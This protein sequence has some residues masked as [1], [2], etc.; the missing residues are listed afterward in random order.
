L[1][2][3]DL[4]KIR[5]AFDPGAAIAIDVVR[6][7]NS[8]LGAALDRIENAHL[9]DDG[10]VINTAEYDDHHNGVDADVDHPTSQRQNTFRC[11]DRNWNPPDDTHPLTAARMPVPKLSAPMVEATQS[12]VLPLDRHGTR[13]EPRLIEPRNP[14]AALRA[15]ATPI[16]PT[17]AVVGPARATAPNTSAAPPVIR[18]TSLQVSAVLVPV[19]GGSQEGCGAPQADAEPP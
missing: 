15:S 3:A 16:P 14:P 5:A 19:L 1:N 7:S 4:A 10:I 8:D 6:Y 2:A 17:T 12:C 9:Q 18:P 13:S 11:C